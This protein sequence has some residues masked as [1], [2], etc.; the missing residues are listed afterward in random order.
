MTI[1]RSI[2]ASALSAEM[3]LFEDAAASVPEG[4]A[5]DAKALSAFFSDVFTLIKDRLAE[6]D[7]GL[8]LPND[9]RYREFEAVLYG[10]LRDGNPD[11]SLFNVTVGL[12]YALETPAKDRVLAGLI[13]DR[14][15]LRSRGINTGGAEPRA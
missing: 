5:E 12:G 8:T 3:T 9:D 11:S 2:D 6:A 7:V 15:F 4:I 1:R 13:R 10:M 14:D